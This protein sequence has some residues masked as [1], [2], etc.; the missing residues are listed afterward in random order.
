M[1]NFDK[2]KKTLSPATEGT[3]LYIECNKVKD[4]I[5]KFPYPGY[6]GSVRASNLQF[7]IFVKNTIF[8]LLQAK[9]S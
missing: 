7:S 9:I 6:W 1:Q 8:V 5:E 4:M 3:K 2:K